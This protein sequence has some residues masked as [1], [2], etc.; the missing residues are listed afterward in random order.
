MKTAGQIKRDKMIR[1]QQEKEL[2]AIISGFDRQPQYLD[3]LVERLISHKNISVR[4]PVLGPKGKGLTPKQ[5]TKRIDGILIHLQKAKDLYLEISPETIRADI[6][7][8]EL[9]VSTADQV[10][11]TRNVER[12][13][14]FP[15]IYGRWV[16]DALS[17]MMNWLN[18]QRGMF[19]GNQFTSKQVDDAKTLFAAADCA[20]AGITV[21]TAADA[22][23]HQIAAWLL[24][25]VDPKRQIERVKPRL[26][27]QGKNK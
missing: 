1:E 27:K 15:D 2:R 18:T 25:K 17:V 23:F 4:G 20:Q 12:K 6:A 19:I 13:S 9:L 16:F 24:D 14:D 10:T 22:P 21:S 7:P 8:M 3:E 5:V 26:I 11:F